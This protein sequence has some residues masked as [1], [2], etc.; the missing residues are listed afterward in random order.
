MAFCWVAWD[1]TINVDED[2][3]RK[4]L[5]ATHFNDTE[6]KPTKSQNKKNY[7]VK[8]KT[9]LVDWLVRI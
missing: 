7:D 3:Q 8:N 1:E 2:R 4:T 5:Q 9:T 6:L